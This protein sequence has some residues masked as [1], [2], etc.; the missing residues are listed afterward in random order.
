MFQKM[1][2]KFLPG[3]RPAEAPIQVAAAPGEDPL[4]DALLLFNAGRLEEAE[5]AYLSLLDAEQGRHVATLQLGLIAHHRGDDRLALE[6][7]RKAVQL[8]PG[9]AQAHNHLGNALKGEGRLDEALA[10]YRRAIALATDYAAPHYNVGSILLEKGETQAA[11][12]C[13][14]TALNLNPCFADAHN[15]R[16]IALVQA[17]NPEAAVESYRRALQLNPDSFEALNNLALALTDLKRCDEAL[18]VCRRALLLRPDSAELDNTNGRVLSELGRFE[19]A[20]A[21]FRRAIDLKPRYATPHANIGMVLNKMNRYHEAIPHYRNALQLD[22]ENL[23]SLSNLG[24]ALGRVGELTEAVAFCAR[25]IA[26]NPGYLHAHYCMG[27]ALVAQGRL[28]EALAEFELA[29]SDMEKFPWAFSN[30]LFTMNYLQHLTQEEIYRESRRWDEAHGE[31]ARARRRPHANDRDPERRLKVGFV[32][33]DFH[34]HSVSFFFQPFLEQQR[35]GLGAGTEYVCYSDVTS[36]DAVTRQLQ[37]A[38]GQWVHAVG[39]SDEVLAQRVR[40]DGIDILFDLAGHTGHRMLTFAEKPAPVQVAWLGYPNTTGLSAMDYRLTDAI[41]DPEGEAD[42][43]HSEKLYRMPNGFLCY[44]PHEEAPKVAPLPAASNG[45][46]TFGSFNNFAK[47]TPEVILLWA[48]L[49]QRVP[50]SQLIMKGRSFADL[51]TRRR[52]EDAFASH[53]ID[54]ERVELRPW[55]EAAEGHLS[56]YGRVDIALDTFPYNGTTTTCEALWMGVPV[57]ALRG[58]RHAARVGA[59]ILSRLSL[60]SLVAKDHEEYLRVACALAGD[61]ERLASLRG[62]LRGI[63]AGSPL[64]DARSFAQSMDTACREIWRRWCLEPSGG[65]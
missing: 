10:S 27:L 57:V 43:Y 7:I 8:D 49:L 31:Q 63:M 41:A 65:S 14:A 61:L 6:L 56:I 37:G 39:L 25:A 4:A 3:A 53:G 44:A 30:F 13:F 24:F 18:E 58:E 55:E 50:A 22:P 35:R 17:G 54:P 60:D 28:P 52:C 20:V 16:G 26:L 19:H 21:C 32:S 45:F 51:P 42:L 38:A 29:R 2:R 47:A 23:E 62:S 12:D 64:C 40:D 15:S 9:Y 34:K 11:L 5:Q 1:F 48:R 36:P 33:P 59:G 46:V